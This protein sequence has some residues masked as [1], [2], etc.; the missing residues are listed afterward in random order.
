LDRSEPKTLALASEY[1]NYNP[2]AVQ[3]AVYA[4]IF[5]TTQDIWSDVINEH[6]GPNQILLEQKKVKQMKMPNQGNL[7]YIT[8]F[9][10]P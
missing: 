9:L 8:N 2:V 6:T 1:F 4:K 7:H 3:Y 5:W 10:H